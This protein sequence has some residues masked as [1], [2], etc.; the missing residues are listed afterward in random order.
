[1][2]RKRW[3]RTFGLTAAFGFVFTS[4]V[5]AQEM[6]QKVDAYLRPD[7]NLV[8]N[9]KPVN[10]AHSALVYDGNSYLPLKE[11]GTLFDATVSW[12]GDTKTIYINRRVSD[13]QPETKDD[14]SYSEITMLGANGFLLDY[15]G[16]KT[17]VL[18]VFTGTETYYRED[19]VKRMGINT[20][21][22][23]KARDKYTGWLFVSEAELK[24]V[25]KEEPKLTY[26]MN[27]TQMYMTTETD[28]QKLQAFEIYTK[29][30]SQV[31][32]DNQ[33][34][35]IVPI[36][37]DPKPGKTNEYR[38]L[39]TDNG[40]FYFYDLVLTERTGGTYMVNAASH[41]NL[42]LGKNEDDSYVK[43]PQ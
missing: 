30:W 9:G 23:A 28:P 26:D 25:W 42:E 4:G 3:I 7:F 5:Y 24:K 18:K 32:I 2:Q 43:Y 27:W 38:M 14:V 6:I 40:H 29:T 15:L 16:A 12:K 10:L 20:S 22:L 21:G 1:M 35:Y 39:V 17:W 41:Y 31:A 33:T 8:L 34:H 37:I 13:L 11:I 19:D 36:V